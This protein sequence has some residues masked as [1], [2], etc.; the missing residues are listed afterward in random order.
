MKRSLIFTIIF[1]TISVFSMKAQ[2]EKGKI[3]LAGTSRLELNIGAESQKTDGNK[4]DGA[5]YSYINFDF[6]PKAGYFFLKDFTAGLFLDINLYSDK[7]KDETNGY[8]TN[9]STFI[10]GPFARYYFELGDKL[11]PYAEG[12]VGFGIDNYKQKSNAGGDWSKYNESV[13]SYRLGGGATYFFNE[14]IGA[15]L[16]LGFLHD[17]YKHKGE[18]GEERSS[19]NEKTIYNEFIM[20]AGVVVMLDK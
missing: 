6:Q 1:L 12:Q 7:D 3:F 2:L 9:G 10:I 8:T 15:D 17:S 5:G 16:F 20:Q 11:V 4:V 14:N 19:H 18:E 13:F